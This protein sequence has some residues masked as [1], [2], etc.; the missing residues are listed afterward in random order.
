MKQYACLI[1][2]G[3]GLCFAAQAASN[4]V[5]APAAT[6]E[7]EALYT[8]A[9]E[10]RAEEILG[11]LN[12]KDAAKAAEVRSVIMNHYRA[13]RSRDAVI[14]AYLRSKGEELEKAS[15]ERQRLY[16]QLTN[17]L[18][19]LYVRTLAGHLTPEQVELVKDRMTYNKVQVTFGAYC[20]IIPK[21]TDGEKAMITKLLKEA[22]E[23]AIDGGSAGEKHAIFERYK[24]RIN[25][26]LKADGHDV[27][28]AF[29][30]WEAK[31]ALANGSEPKPAASN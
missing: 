19:E 15:V 21:L 24:E 14:D 5:T 26:Q 20:E 29:E 18:H 22:R 11:S 12:L 10:R 4:L 30:E 27:D 16:S 23:E 25:A 8:A 6:S 28:K 17:P 9:I 31:Q 1:T 7:V 13:L 2:L 3:A